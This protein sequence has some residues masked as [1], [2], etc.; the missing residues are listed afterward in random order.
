MIIRN[1]IILCRS[2]KKTKKLA[3]VCTLVLTPKRA[4]L[5]ACHIGSFDLGICFNSV[6]E[7][8]AL[9]GVCSS[10]EAK[11]VDERVVDVG[12]EGA[13]IALNFL[14]KG[15]VLDQVFTIFAI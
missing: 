8:Q 4:D 5:D 15:T 7:V 3:S 1:S 9:I 12:C 14:L 2:S 11:F 10:I 6:G 13:D